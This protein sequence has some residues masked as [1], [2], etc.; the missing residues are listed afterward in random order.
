MAVEK[1]VPIHTTV[2]EDTYKKLKN[3]YGNG[4]LKEGIEKA[5]EIAEN[6]QYTIKE[7]L[8][9]IADRVLVELRGFT[10]PP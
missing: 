4:V 5:V 10:P 1:K 8:Q 3:K 9:R 7:E 6:K 2:S